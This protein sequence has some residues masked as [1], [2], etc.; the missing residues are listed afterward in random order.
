MKPYGIIYSLADPRT[1]EVRY[2]GQTTKT[3]RGRLSSHL[4]PSGLRKK[5]HVAAWLTGLTK[6]GLQPVAAVLHEAASR[7]ELDQLEIAAIAK[8]GKAF[9]LTNHAPGGRANAGA[10]RSAETCARISAARLGKKLSEE[11]K[12]KLS[13]ALRG[14]L[15]PPEHRQRIGMAL[16]GRKH[17]EQALRNMSRAAANRDSTKCAESNRARKWTDEARARIRE[18]KRARDLPHLPSDEAV[19][20]AYEKGLSQAAVG[21]ALGV[22]QS[23]IGKRLAALNKLRPNPAQKTLR[24]CTPQSG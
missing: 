21:R 5:L 2:V 11:T 16:K 6:A 4:T 3:L 10:V 19:V 1:G 12:A 18:A 9:P 20:A 14:R 15:M 23:Y 24:R 7:E 17:T 22:A 13:A 8:F